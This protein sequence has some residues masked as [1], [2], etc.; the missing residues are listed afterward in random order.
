MRRCDYW[1]GK[2]GLV[3]H[4]RSFAPAASVGRSSIFCATNGY[5][6]P[7]SLKRES[8]PCLPPTNTSSRSSIMFGMSNLFLALSGAC[9]GIL[10]S[11]SA[12]IAEYCCQ[13]L[14]P[15]VEVSLLSDVTAVEGIGIRLVRDG[16]AVSD[17]ADVPTRS[18]RLDHLHGASDVALRFVRL[19]Q[20]WP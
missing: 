15:V 11:A 9:A 20:G 19:H 7:A 10:R 17:N 16:R 4:R 6:P 1:G 14:A 2:L 5:W 8:L 18:Q 12:R 3:V 13:L